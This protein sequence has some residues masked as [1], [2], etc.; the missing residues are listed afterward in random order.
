M[1]MLNHVEV[2]ALEARFVEDEIQRAL[3]EVEGDKALGL[4][5]FPFRF[6][7]SF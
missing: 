5:G 1:P 4:D 3:M 7:Q 6:P 2:T